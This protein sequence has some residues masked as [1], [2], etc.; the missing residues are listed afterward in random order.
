L[1][2]EAALRSS[3]PR[4]FCGFVLIAPW[5]ALLAY[6]M[7]S[8]MVTPQRLIAP[9]YPLLLPLLLIGA[10]QSQIVR[11]GMVARAGR[12]GFSPGL[13]RFDS[14]AGSSAVAGQNHFIPGF[15]AQHPG[16]RLVDPRVESFIRF[17][18]N[19]GNALAG[20][21]AFAAARNQVSS[22]F[23]AA[24]MIAIFHCGVRFLNGA[25]SILN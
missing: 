7:K 12:R 9:Y 15:H 21:R 19:A 1:N 8:G 11:R 18:P 23:S 10:G 17:T 6:G 4:A 3:I 13:C 20:V 2:G 5:I 25:W 22:A 24:R 16:Q 14:V